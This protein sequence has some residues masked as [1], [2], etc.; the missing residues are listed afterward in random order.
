LLSPI[1]QA[2]IAAL[3]LVLMVGMGA[4]L[5]PADFR[6]AVEQRRAVAIGFL[7][8]YFWMPALAY[9]LVRLT[10]LGGETAL[11]FLLIACTGGGS[12]SNVFSYFAR[13]DVALSV[14]MTAVSTITSVFMMPALLAVVAAGTSASGAPVPLASIAMTLAGM[15]VPLS[16]GMALRTRRPGLAR[17]VERI[18][19]IAGI[20]MLVF[21][22]A[23]SAHR[24]VGFMRGA[25]PAMWTACL[26][27]AG[28]GLGLGY[29]ASTLA[30]LEL[31]ARRAVAF[32]TGFQS[33][34]V[35]IA[36]V[37]TSFPEEKQM[38]LLHMPL[39]YA[40]LMLVLAAA[41]TVALRFGQP[42][43]R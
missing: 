23:V 2:L 38:A 35:A 3:T 1:E 7:S 18:G 12:G 34:P 42:G 36:V 28:L 25:T 27:L 16:I 6:R 11:G 29:A 21:L 14:T 33:T 4:S 26:G 37:L 10:G 17:R 20:A 31:P 13:A 19:G 22:V 8:Q 40:T 24:Y 30:R 9:A 32:E 43:G 41:V 39:L 5:S 15:L